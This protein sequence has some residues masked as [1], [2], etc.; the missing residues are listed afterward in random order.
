MSGSGAIF[1][2]TRTMLRDHGERLADLQQTVASGVRLRR[3]SDGPAEAFRLLGLRNQSHSLE[4]YA[5]NLARVSD[6]LNVTSSVLSKM[7]ETMTRVRELVTQGV[8]GTYSAENRQFIAD[9]INSLTE[10][11]VSLANTEHGGRHLFGGSE[12]GSVPYATEYD[13]GRLVRVTYTGSRQDV[14]VPVAPGVSYS[15]LLIGDEVFR[16]DEREAPQF[17][18]RTGAAAGAGTG[19]VRGDVWLTLSHGSTT[20]L[21]ASGVAPGT[22]SAVADTVLGNGHTLTIDAPGKTLRLDGGAE[23]TFS[24]TET[25][26]L[27]ANGDGDVV[28]VDV[29]SLDGGFVGSVNIQT[30]GTLSI[31]DGASQ[32]AADFSNACVGVTDSATGRVLY[33][34]CTGIERVGLEPVRNPGTYDLF[35]AL[36]TVRDVMLNTRDVSQN[37]Q[38]ALLNQVFDAISE[39]T[40][41]LTAAQARVGARLGVLATLGEGLDDLR[42]YTDDRAAALEN[43]DIVQVA[44]ELAREQNLYEMTLASAS[45]LLQLSLFD[46]L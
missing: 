25:D 29:T 34:N 24:G 16:S 27:V 5:G 37:E 19:S 31:D 12:T 39:V 6:T 45:R 21:G 14:M 9:E 40:A 46:Y 32:T 36:L 1:N 33:V 35:G 17:L 23:V 42:A 38:T 41:G 26:L 10:Q 20:Y 7:S 8:S 4:T 30:T 11:L 44:T 22:S 15:A 18:G 2:T 43:A 13:G 28:C 3:A